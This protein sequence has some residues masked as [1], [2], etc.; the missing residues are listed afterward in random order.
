MKHDSFTQN[1]KD[2]ITSN[3]YTNDQYLPLLSGFV[4][5]NGIISISQKK[6]I[7]SLQ[8]ENSKIAKLIYRCFISLFNI[9]PQ[10]SYSKKMKLDKCVVYHLTIYDQVVEILK[11]L[12]IYDGLEKIYPKEILEN[13]GVRFFISGVFLASGSV[14]PPTSNNYHLQMV[15]TDEEDAKFL[16]KILNRFKNEKNMDFKYIARRNKF[17]VYL[18]KADQIT[19][20]LALVNASYSM[21]D[22]EN[23]RVE[24]DYI[25]SENRYQI[26]FNANFQ[27][28]I[29]KANE[30]IED[31]NEI[32]KD[33]GFIHL[34]EKERELALSRLN[35]P[36]APLSTLV[37]IL[38][39]KD[40]AISKSGAS[41]IFNKFH[42][43]AN[44]LRSKK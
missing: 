18:K 10:F 38:K 3:E 9:T 44:S 19:I 25:N 37:E 41:R 1:V 39:S 24:K 20:F 29:Q 35:N 13:D 28:T 22:F 26:C 21:M 40:I 15:V 4:K 31:I 43:L 5:T 27:K 34:N 23:S 6:V 30:Q 2:E 11:K 36:E 14:N 33:Y 16:I 32:Q 12:Q 7:L 17:V 8:T 42:D